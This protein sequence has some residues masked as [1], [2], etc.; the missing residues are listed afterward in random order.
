MKY[1]A[2]DTAGDPAAIL[3]K[4]GD[5]TRFRTVTEQKRTSEVLLPL[6]DGMLD[7]SGLTLDDLDFM[8]VVT[9][10]GSFTGIRIGVNTVKTFAYVKNTPIA[11]VDALKKLTYNDIPAGAKS[12]ICAVH[13]YANFCYVAVYDADGTE[14]DA[15]QTLEYAAARDYITAHENAVTFADKAACERLEIECLADNAEVSL[16]R[17][18]EAFYSSGK[19]VG[20]GDVEP[21]YLMKSQ[22]ERELENKEKRG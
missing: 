6:V 19:T 21:F 10:P 22:A 14:I 4:N 5:K 1:L 13:A 11:A 17:A 18:A 8:A 15:P 12:I 20:Y 9:G 16:A 2:I 3:V 7:E